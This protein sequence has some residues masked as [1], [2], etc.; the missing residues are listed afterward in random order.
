MSALSLNAFKEYLTDLDVR[1][2]ASEY[3]TE[4]PVEIYA[5]GGFS[6]MYYGLRFSGTEDIDSVKL[7]KEPVKK[8][9][10]K[11]ALERGLPIDW[12]NDI[13][14]SGLFYDL[15]SF[16]WNETDWKFN[17]I[18]LFVVEM[19]DLLIN[20]LGVAD[21][22]LMQK[23]DRIHFRDFNDVEGIIDKLGCDYHSM[24]ELE[25]WFHERGIKLTDYPNV[26]DQF[27]ERLADDGLYWPDGHV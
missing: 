23:T 26:Y 4:C 21:K 22:V 19:E 13:P 27:S 17:N 10:R 1:L 14:A 3:K 25:E 7:L 12:L 20:K 11:I 9:V 15:S 24:E 8:L 2:S 16:R 6:L 18:R 5:I